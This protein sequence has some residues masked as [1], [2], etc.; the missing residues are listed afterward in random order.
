MNTLRRKERE[1]Q[2]REE[3]ILK[4]AHQMLL[5]VG[6]VGLTIDRIAEATEYSKGTIYQHFS[7]KED[8]LLALSGQAM[9]KRLDLF[10]RAAAFKGKTRERM[11]AIG[12]ADELFVLLYPDHFRAE[13]IFKI[14]SLWAK[15]SPERREK[16]QFYDLRCL[17]INV[18]I[19]RDAI[20]Q[21]DLE[22]RLL[23]S[24]EELVYTLVSLTFGSH[25]LALTDGPII[26]QLSIENPF[27]LLRA[28]VQI[29]LDGIGWQ[30]LTN[31]WDYKATYN[32]IQQEIF[33]GE[34]KLAYAQ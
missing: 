26:Q 4:V 15:T 5:E 19:V 24:P 13:Q 6:Y 9:Q 32:R 7:C 33:P 29:L 22:L 14:D 28:S 10:E 27:T 20:A 30:P 21:S 12:Q 34:C 1:Y 31:E 16:L 25:R 3:L 11:T 2:Q 18:D 23:K 17:S 8:I